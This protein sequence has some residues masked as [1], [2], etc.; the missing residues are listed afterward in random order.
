MWRPVREIFRSREG[1]PG[2]WKI[3][4]HAVSAFPAL[5]N[6]MTEKGKDYLRHIL[7]LAVRSLNV[8]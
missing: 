5:V 8:M 3:D 6:A 4:K 1:S 2:F 7:P